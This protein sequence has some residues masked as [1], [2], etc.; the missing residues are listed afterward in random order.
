VTPAV[1]AVRQYRRHLLQLHPILWSSTWIYKDRDPLIRPHFAQALSFQIVATIALIISA[2]LQLT[3]I[4]YLTGFATWS[5]SWC[6]ASR[7]R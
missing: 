7:A 5:A 6:S 1:V 4:G 3:L 2:V